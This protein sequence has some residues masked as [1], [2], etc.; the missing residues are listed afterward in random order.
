MKNKT[1]LKCEIK[2]NISEFHK[3]KYSKDGYQLYCKECRKGYFNYKYRN[4]WIKKKFIYTKEYWLKKKLSN[5]IS[6]LIYHSL[7]GNKKGYHWE[8][9]VSYTLK[10]LMVHLESLFKDGMS[11]ENYGKW[12]LDHIRPVSSFKFSSYED[13]EFKEC[14][15]LEN[16]QPLWAKENLKKGA[17][18]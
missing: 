17:S 3:D 8:K 13:K 16:L 11:W 14:W 18:K 10:D 7:K 6:T 4:K 2:K 12:H 5:N 9:I 1:C 15:A